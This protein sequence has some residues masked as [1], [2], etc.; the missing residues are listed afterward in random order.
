MVDAV[1]SVHR[2]QH[3]DTFTIGDL[4]VNGRHIGQTLEYPWRGN[5]AWD[6]TQSKGQNFRHVSCVR[7]GIYRAQLRTDNNHGVRLELLGT[8]GRTVI[9]IHAGNTL[10]R[11][12]E[13]CILCGSVVHATG[14]EPRILPG[15]SRFTRD[16]FIQAI[17]GDLSSVKNPSEWATKMNSVHVTV[18][19]IGMPPGAWAVR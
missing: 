18:K 12:S 15:T 13:G 2:R 6:S 4:F 7:E 17:F 14:V 16:R 11:D 9:E 5:T 3:G 19:V 1:V 8:A 10:I